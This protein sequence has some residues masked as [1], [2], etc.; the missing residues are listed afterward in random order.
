M[1]RIL[2]FHSKDNTE[3][4][5]GPT[6]YMDAEYDKVAVRIYAETAPARDAKIDIYDDGVSIFA[7]RSSSTLDSDSTPGYPVF[8]AGTAKTYAVLP[9]GQN[10][11]DIA[12]DF[13]STLIEEGSWV[14]CELEDS[15][16]GENFT[17]QLELHPVSEGESG[18][19]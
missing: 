3:D 2:V 14:Y 13:N 10:S 15:G 11:E 18:E 19:D 5:I 6:Y 12:D 8:T 4:R 9:E 17:V 1:N 16:E 7:D